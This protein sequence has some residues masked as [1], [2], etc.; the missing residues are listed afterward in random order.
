MLIM[1]KIEK[2]NKNQTKK[3]LHKNNMTKILI[4][5]IKFSLSN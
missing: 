2:I 1:I 4:Y 3:L 5:K